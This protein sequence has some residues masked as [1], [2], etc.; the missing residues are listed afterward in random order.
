M[1][2]SLPSILVVDDEPAMR[3]LLR[4]TLEASGYAV[5]EAD[6]GRLGLAQAATHA[7]EVIILDLS[8]PDLS[9]VEVV[10]QLR[11]WSKVP[12][13][14]LT[15]RTAESDKVDALDAG[16]DDFLTKPFGAAELNARLRALRRRTR[17]EEET[18]RLSIGDL[19]VDFVTRQVWRAGVEVKLTAR[20]Y[21]IFR[22]LVLNRG[23]VLTHRQILLE[24]W[25]PAAVNNTH[26]LRLHM[27]H[28]RQK[29]EANPQQPRYLKTEWGIGFRLVE[30]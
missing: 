25:G 19:L 5:V 9:G 3:R 12:V 1:T 11:E 17:A 20:E 26:Y 18:P 6:T 27:T 10:R 22:L 23:K 24:L 16:A 14:V 30:C 4:I 13:L 15:V 8:L 29:L 21:D 2:P 28:L 7:P